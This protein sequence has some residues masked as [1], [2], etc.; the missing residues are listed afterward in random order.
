MKTNVSKLHELLK[1]R[2]K[3]DSLY[4]PRRCGKTLLLC[5]ELVGAIEVGDFKTVVVGIYSNSNL[6]FLLPM[7]FDVLKEHGMNYAYVKQH[8]KLL[9]ND[10]VVRFIEERKVREE[11]VGISDYYY[12]YLN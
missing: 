11:T 8:N 6:E 9:C 4:L 3:V 5:H 12:Q 2:N 10:K 7:L 1:L